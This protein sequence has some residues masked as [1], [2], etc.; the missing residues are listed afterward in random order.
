MSI[1]D[2][3]TQIVKLTARGAVRNEPAFK[4][5]LS[6]V[7]SNATCNAMNM[8]PNEILIVRKV[9]DPM[10]GKL[11][12]HAQQ[13]LPDREWQ[14]AVNNQLNKIYQS[15]EKQKKGI[16]PGEAEA[17]VFADTAELL[18]CYTS[19]IVNARTAQCWWW[20]TLK[21]LVNV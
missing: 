5:G 15:A 9:N 20:K 21:K 12:A 1:T 17:V 11:S 3:K 18:A 2:D 13:Y 19:D 10:P 7:L 16:L 8:S 14:S 4:L 6:S